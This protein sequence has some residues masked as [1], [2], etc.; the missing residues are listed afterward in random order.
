M[1]IYAD[2]SAL[3]R[4]LTDEAES[5]SWIRWAEA[6]AEDI[7]TSPLGLTELRRVADPLGADVRQRAREL[8]ASLTV[9]R[10]SDESLRA[11]TNAASVLPP[12]AAIHLGIAL[13]N[14]EVGMIATYDALLAKVAALHRMRVAA[15][16]RPE[17]WWL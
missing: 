13:S 1:L 16:G 3:S 4:S 8:A 5:A 17:G 6:H 11:A 12:F 15:P 10:F 7:V 9:V 2:G 14:K